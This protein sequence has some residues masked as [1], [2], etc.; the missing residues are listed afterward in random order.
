MTL[1][2]DVKF[3]KNWLVVWKMTWGIWQF[4][5]RALES[6]KVI[7]SRKCMSLKSAEELTCVVSKLTWGIWQILTR[8]LDVSNIWNLMGFF[9]T[10]Y[11]FEL[12]KSTEELC[13]MT[14][15]NDAKFEEELTCP[16]KIGTTIWQILTQAFECL[17]N[18]RFNGL[19]LTKVYTMFGLKK[20]RTVMFD[21]N[22]DWCKIWWKTDLYF[23]KWHKE[24][25][26]FSQAEK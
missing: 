15:K 24:F 2:S 7:Q 18:L 26:K 19:P 17:K 14:L 12:K 1:T 20:Y 22:E 5:A 9:W 13:F 10:K 6:L 11:M 4:F 25:G 23:P 8:A 16:F 3:E 21:V